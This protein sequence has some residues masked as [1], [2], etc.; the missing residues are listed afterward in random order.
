MKEID[1]SIIIVNYNTLQMTR[2]CID[3]IFTKTKGINFEIILVDNASTDGSQNY[4]KGDKRILFIQSNKNLGFGRAN[5]LGAK[6]S[7]GKYLFL[8][9]SDTLLVN[10]AIKIFYDQMEALSQKIAFIGAPLLCKDCKAIGHSY[11]YFP[12]LK[13]FF[14]DVFYYYTRIKLNKEPKQYVGNYKVD[15][16]TGAD[17][18]CRNHLI[19]KHGLFDEDFFMYFEEVELQYRYSKMGYESMIVE[20]PKIIHLSGASFN[21]KKET[22]HKKRLMI[23]RSRFLF[24]KKCYGGWRYA[25]FKLLSLFY[26][27]SFRDYSKEQKR[28]YL[29][30]FRI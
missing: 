8:L 2:Q 6:Y 29:S 10:N 5:N 17:L 19:K 28:E 27:P 25:T 15:Y 7:K 12:S 26:L 24:M 1:V 18:F 21:S 23:F 9:N 13:T 20:G 14:F 4:F 16:V 30:F 11:Y 3:S 22:L